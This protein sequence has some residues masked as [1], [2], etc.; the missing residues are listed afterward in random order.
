MNERNLDIEI[1]IQVGFKEE[2]IATSH[3]QVLSKSF[4]SRIQ[5]DPNLARRVG[6]TRVEQPIFKRM[7][8]TS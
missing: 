1:W 2:Q 5:D 8:C 6:R 3:M 7:M 4:T